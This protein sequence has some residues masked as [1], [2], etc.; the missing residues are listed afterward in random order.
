VTEVDADLPE[1]D[2]YVSSGALETFSLRAAK[3]GVGTEDDTLAAV[4]MP[5]RFPMRWQIC[6][7]F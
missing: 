6:G 5:Y 3:S 1:R 7:V 2:V 4:L